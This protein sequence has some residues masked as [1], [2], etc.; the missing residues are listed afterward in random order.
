MRPLFCCTVFFPEIGIFSN[1][2]QFCQ[3][4]RNTILIHDSPI[5]EPHL[6][7]RKP[8]KEKNIVF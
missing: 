3:I 7:G 1:L 8:K 6:E 2:K 4:K 5:P